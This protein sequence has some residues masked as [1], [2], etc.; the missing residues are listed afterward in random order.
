MLSHLT[1]DLREPTEKY[2]QIKLDKSKYKS[3][4]QKHKIY[5]FYCL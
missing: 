2:K 1:K 5:A 4:G 3:E